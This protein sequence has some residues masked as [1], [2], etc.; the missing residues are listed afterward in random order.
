MCWAAHIWC[1]PNLWS[2][3]NPQVFDPTVVLTTTRVDSV[4]GMVVTPGMFI[5]QLRQYC[6]QSLIFNGCCNAGKRALNHPVKPHV[7]DAA[8]SFLPDRI[9]MDNAGVWCEGVQFAS[10]PVSKRA[11]TA[12]SRSHSCTA[13]FA[14]WCRAFPACPDSTDNPLQLRQP[15]QRAGDRHFCSSEKFT[16]RGTAC[17]MPT[18]PPTYSI[19]FCALPA[20][21]ALARLRHVGNSL[22]FQGG[23]P[24]FQIAA[25]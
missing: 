2:R 21:G 25:G 17:A 23:E 18:P 15:F 4:T 22:R 12:I 11:P 6:C 5:T 7:P 20:S 1:C 14:V 13:K 24:W 16:Q 3:R 10:H 9:H 8:C 19:G